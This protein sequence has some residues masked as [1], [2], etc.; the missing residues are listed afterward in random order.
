RRKFI[1]A[2]T[3]M[4]L[5]IAAKPQGIFFLPLWIVLILKDINRNSLSYLLYGLLR[6]GISLCMGV[7]LILLWDAS[8]PET[9]IFALGASN[10]SPDSWLV[11]PEDWLTRAGLWWHYLR[12]M[13]GGDMLTLA[14]FFIISIFVLMQRHRINLLLWLWGIGYLCGHIILRFNI[15]DRY[16]LILVPIMTL[17]LARALT[18]LSQHFHTKGT[19]LFIY[20]AIIAGLLLPGAWWASSGDAPIGGDR[21]YYAGI[22]DLTMYLNEKPVAT[23]IYDRWLGWQLDYYMGQ[24]SDKRRVYYPDVDSLVAG[25]LAL[26]ETETR[27]FIAPIDADYEGWLSGLNDAGFAV[28]LDRQFER[29]VVYTLIP[30]DRRG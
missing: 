12:E 26:F 25:A 9:S 18:T 23:V 27:Y 11:A 10:N 20:I 3:F 14:A 21:G 7:A 13:M 2:G 8:R 22:D 4:A 6:A 15:Y 16:L 30:P 24:W 5:S 19:R 17:L 29:F 28:S 1:L